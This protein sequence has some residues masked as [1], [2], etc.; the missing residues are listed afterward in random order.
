LN[1]AAT[2]FQTSAATLAGV[3]AAP[4]LVI[5]AAIEPVAVKVDP[6]AVIVNVADIPSPDMAPMSE[7]TVKV[8]PVK[9]VSALTDP[10][11]AA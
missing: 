2:E 3:T 7:L 4:W 11:K 10:P 6:D 9:E 1:T 5:S 8:I